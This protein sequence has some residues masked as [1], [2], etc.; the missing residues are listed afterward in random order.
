MSAGGRALRFAAGE[1]RAAG[2]SAGGVRGMRLQDGDEVAGLAT[3][4]GD[5]EL[6]VVSEQGIG[7]R[8]PFAEY[9]VKG[10]GGQGVRTFRAS[11]RTGRLVG[12]HAVRPERDD[13]LLVS[14]EGEAKWTRADAIVRE[15]RDARG[16]AIVRIGR[17]DA[18]AFC[19][20]VPRHGGR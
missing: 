19:A 16:A 13:L 17:G 3:G 8:T 9:A 14:R 1:L 5:E 4:R 20:P 18:L 7:K 10:R 11:A 12:A 6:L 15:R 2:R